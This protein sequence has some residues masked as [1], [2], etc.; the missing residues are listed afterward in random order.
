MM[1]G[2]PG[3][4]GK[5]VAAA[6]LRKG[7]KMAPYSLT[8]PQIQDT[9]VTVD[10]MSGGESFTV[11]LLKDGAEGTDE[12]ILEMKARFGSDLICID[13]THP[14]AVNSNAELYARLGLP[15]VMG[16]TGGDRSKLMEDTV[17]S[18][19]Y[20]VI[21]PNMGKQIVAL[22][23]A[24]DYMAREFP[25]AF[26]GYSLDITESHQSSKADTSGTAKALA[27]D[28]AVL[29]GAPFDVESEIT[30][31]RDAP[32]Q[33]AFGVPEEYLGGHAFHMYS[34][35]SGDGTVEFQFRHNVCGRRMYAEGTADA[36]EFLA[37]QMASNA[38]KR[39]YNMIDVLKMG[40]I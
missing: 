16:T 27:N 3:N 6:C 24:I 13:Y 30:M 36:V 12:K 18:G 31:I 2:L 34:L 8:G 38:Q 22:Q 19:V 32:G 11:G 10:D 15:F 25:G 7:F 5:E 9:E 28:F 14:T 39:V 37:R 29:T 23:T 17:K 35:R 20:A 4:M 33:K 21:A 40:G 1:N 26:G